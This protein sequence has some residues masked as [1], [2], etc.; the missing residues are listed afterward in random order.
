MVKWYKIC[1]RTLKDVKFPLTGSIDSMQFQPKIQR[2][3]SVNLQSCSK[4]Y[5]K[6]GSYGPHKGREVCLYKDL[7]TQLY[8]KNKIILLQG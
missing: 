2:E 7:I 8:N 1:A 4:V 6:S 3:F 5:I